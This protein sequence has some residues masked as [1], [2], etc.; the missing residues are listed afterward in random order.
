MQDVRIEDLTEARA[1][2]ARSRKS[3][4]SGVSSWV[5][6]TVSV[7]QAIVAWMLTVPTKLRGLAS[8]S[9]EE[10]RAM[11]SRIWAAIKHEA[12]HFWVGSKLLYAEL[13]ISANL[14]SQVIRGHS[15]TR[16]ERKQLTRTTADLFR[17]VPL[18]V[19][20]IVPFM[21]LALPVLLKLFPNMLPSTFQDKLKHEEALK[22][23]LQARIEMAKFLQDTTEEMA[24]MLSRS[25]SGD[26]QTTAAE[27]YEFMRR[28]RS[29]AQVSNS[30]IKRFAKLF[31]DEITLDSVDRVQL[32]NMAKFV[33]I[34]A[35]GTDTFLRFQLRAKLR[36]IK[37]DDRLIA[38]EGV[39]SLTFEELRA[40]CRSRGM[41]W[42]G[43]SSASMRSQIEDWLDLSLGAALPSSLL[44]LSRA[45]TIT[46]RRLEDPEK[47]AVADLEATLASLPDGVLM[48]AELDACPTDDSPESKMRRLE[49]LRQE[50]DRIA[51]EKLDLSEALA[52]VAAAPA[53]QRDIALEEMRAASAQDAAASAAAI[54][55][56]GLP[57]AAGAA[58]SVLPASESL[59]AAPLPSPPVEQSS[60]GGELRLDEV[61]VQE[62]T[63][64][65]LAERRRAARRLARALATMAGAT[66]TVQERSEFSA[67]LRKEVERYEAG[68]PADDGA[69]R[70]LS[71]RLSSVLSGLD[72]E[73]DAVDKRI[74]RRLHRLDLN[75]D[76]LLDKS[77][78]AQFLASD[79]LKDTLKESGDIRTILGPEM[80]DKDGSVKLA[81]LVELASGDDDDDAGADGLPPLSDE[82]IAAREAL[83]LKRRAVTP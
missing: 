8:M 12:H 56:S 7:V 53:E 28:V 79:L 51:E 49:T 11:L 43:E 75:R 82:E 41:R 17:L 60:E 62:V 54:P 55:V 45:F 32:V 36:E 65:A 81:D 47:A 77:E 18:L 83:L 50:Q 37:A 22:A 23:Q 26:V 34:P 44:I 71:A 38:A 58:E 72:K 61:S 69:S 27:L 6:S 39:N 63:A 30:D 59:S 10:W 16:R 13:Q 64:A 2:A 80:F 29:G 24:K 3:E 33:N 14:V 35:Y 52:A 70:L 31:N 19:I 74:G 66:P 20:V 21:E 76:G 42:D 15:L 46:H 5:S 48:R 1:E 40:A 78:L 68:E 4:A 67:L 57:G 25:R 73:I 9:R